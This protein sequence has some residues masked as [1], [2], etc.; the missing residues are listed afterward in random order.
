MTHVSRSTRVVKCQ[1][2]YTLRSTE[3]AK[4]QGHS[5]RVNCSMWGLFF[6]SK[7]WPTLSTPWW[8]KT[9][10]ITFQMYFFPRNKSAKD[11]LNVS[12][13]KHT[14]HISTFLKYLTKRAP[15]SMH[16]NVIREAATNGKITFFSGQDLGSWLPGSWPARISRAA[17]RGA[18][19]YQNYLIQ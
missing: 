9:Q 15:A 6:F 13:R 2:F 7:A 1:F 17:S 18:F 3:T 5:R 11:N 10:L 16:P 14:S 12:H 8:K 19:T 4:T